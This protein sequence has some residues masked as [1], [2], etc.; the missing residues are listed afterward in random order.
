[1]TKLQSHMANL[2]NIESRSRA[3]TQPIR[4]RLGSGL[5]YASSP[6]AVRTLNG[7]KREPELAGC[8]YKQTDNGRLRSK[9]PGSVFKTRYSYAS[10]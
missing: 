8:S 2:G 6:Q 10:R 4:I 1:M 9:P 3:A 5:I 7:P